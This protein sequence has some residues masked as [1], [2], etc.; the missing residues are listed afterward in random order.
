MKTRLKLLLLLVLVG[1]LSAFS[2]GYVIFSVGRCREALRALEF[3]TEVR[4]EVA[5]M[6]IYV[7]EMVTARQD[8]QKVRGEEL[9]QL[10]RASLTY[11]TDSLES[12]TEKKTTW[13]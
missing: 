13:Y 7:E 3:A 4:T 5:L 12:L 6:A 2:A 9:T 1:V 8:E 11:T 10:L